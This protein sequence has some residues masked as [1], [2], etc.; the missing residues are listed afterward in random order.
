MK[1]INRHSLDIK[2][3][4]EA[5]SSEWIMGPSSEWVPYTVESLHTLLRSRDEIINDLME[6][7]RWRS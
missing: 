1:I 5:E 7:V 4:T 6:E 2:E 3:I